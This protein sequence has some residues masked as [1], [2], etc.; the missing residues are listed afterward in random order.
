MTTTDF[1]GS[2]NNRS[3]A[4]MAYFCRLSVITDRGLPLISTPA[5]SEVTPRDRTRIE[6]GRRCGLQ[7]SETLAACHRL[8]TWLHLPC[9]A[10]RQTNGRGTGA[11]ISVA[12]QLRYPSNA[13]RR[14]GVTVCARATRLQRAMQPSV[15]QFRNRAAAVRIG[16]LVASRLSSQQDEFVQGAA[17]QARKRS[18]GWARRTARRFRKLFRHPVRPSSPCRTARRCPGGLSVTHEK[19]KHR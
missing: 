8:D 14:S 18:A 5:S 9:R 2:P 1:G 10:R 4:D 15:I 12:P 19:G 6:R 13:V 17:V 11:S 3:A 16:D 7:A